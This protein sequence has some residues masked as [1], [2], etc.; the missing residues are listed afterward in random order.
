MH[1]DSAVRREPGTLVTNDP[2]NKPET[3][4]RREGRDPCSRFRAQW[5]M[6]IYI[7]PLLITC[8]V[9]SQ[10]HGR[11]GES[12]FFKELGG[13]EDSKAREIKRA[14]KFLNKVR[15]SH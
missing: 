11:K 6:Y 4:C 7:S 9:I 12:S 2:N 13:E 10:Y 5:S 3:R 8:Y 1:N 15:R 14:K